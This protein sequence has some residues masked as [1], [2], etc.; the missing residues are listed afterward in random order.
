M[1]GQVID[2]DRWREERARVAGDADEEQPVFRI[3][4]NGSSSPGAAAARLDGVSR[5]GNR[6]LVTAWYGAG[7]WWVDF[8]R[9]P[10]ALDGVV[11]DPRSTW[12]NTV[13]WN[14]MPGAETWSAKEYKGHVYTGD[15][16]RGFDVFRLAPDHCAGLGC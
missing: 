10:S 5:L 13:G 11:E 15:M 2:F 7:T 3:G 12:G 8:S 14:V 16:L 4:G 9:P 6:Q 1:A